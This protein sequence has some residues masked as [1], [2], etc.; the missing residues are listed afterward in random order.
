M[1]Q[2]VS[3]DDGTAD[4]AG[5]AQRPTLD[6]DEPTPPVGDGMRRSGSSAASLGYGTV[7]PTLAPSS[8][9]Q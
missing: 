4:S 8:N 3:V 9:A 5:G 2:P 6:D 7:I 1:A